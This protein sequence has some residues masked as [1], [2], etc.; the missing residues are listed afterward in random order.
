M[1]KKHVI[2]NGVSFDR[3]ENETEREIF[4]KINPSLLKG[5]KRIY[6]F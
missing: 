2:S 5:E 6:F 1:R 3:R 4:N